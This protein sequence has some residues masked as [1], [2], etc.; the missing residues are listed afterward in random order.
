MLRFWVTHVESS[1]CLRHHLPRHLWLSTCIVALAMWALSIELAL[2]PCCA[3][4]ITLLALCCHPCCAG[5][6]ALIVLCCRRSRHCLP[7][8][9]WHCSGI[10]ALVPLASSFVLASLPSL[11]WHCHPHCAG[12][13]VLITL[14]LLLLL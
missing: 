14:M 3:G 11:R 9:P 13:V 4:I 7:R 1:L 6:L 8:G 2:L 10:V 5:I 12:V